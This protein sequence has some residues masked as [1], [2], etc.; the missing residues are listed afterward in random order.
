MTQ[1]RRTVFRP[2]GPAGRHASRG[3]G[4][5]LPPPPYGLRPPD[6]DGRLFSLEPIAPYRTA[7]RP[8]ISLGEP[9]RSGFLVL[10]LA[11]ADRNPCSTPCHGRRPTIPAQIVMDSSREGTSCGPP[12]VSEIARLPPFQVGEMT[13]RAVAATLHRPGLPPSSIYGIRLRSSPSRGRAAI[14]GYRP[15]EGGGSGKT[16]LLAGWRLPP[17]PR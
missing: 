16:I 4:G 2:S 7:A 1:E 10:P 17:R 11:Q 6:G 3:P 9:N 5:P 14:L 12:P 15:T 8:G 13:E